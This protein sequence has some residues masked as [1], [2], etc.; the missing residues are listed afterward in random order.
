MTVRTAILQNYQRVASLPNRGCAS[1][2]NQICFYMHDAHRRPAL[3]HLGSA[4]QLEAAGF[5]QMLRGF[6]FG[7]TVPVRF[8]ITDATHTSERC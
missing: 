2:D 5:K 4:A 6:L 8:P 7:P 3:H 1:K